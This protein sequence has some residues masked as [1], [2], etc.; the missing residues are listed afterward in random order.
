MIQ[1]S[2]VI[3]AGVKF[4]DITNQ[5]LINEHTA[6]LLLKSSDQISFGLMAGTARPI[7]DLRLNPTGWYTRDL[8]F[9]WQTSSA[10]LLFCL[11]PLQVIRVESERNS[12]IVATA[13][14]AYAIDHAAESAE[15]NAA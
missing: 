7:N 12:I 15:L 13:M 1:N 8:T 9:N 3:I 11:T 4:I 14:H 10:T 5:L 2:T 6:P